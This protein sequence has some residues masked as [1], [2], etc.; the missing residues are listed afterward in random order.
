TADFER[1]VELTFR[2]SP[3]VRTVEAAEFCVAGPQVTPHVVAQQLLPAGSRRTLAAQLEPGRYRL[4]A[5]DVPGA[6][7][8]VV[9]A[10]GAAE[11]EVQAPAEGWP[12]ADEL[13]LAEASTVHLENAT[14]E[15]QLLVLERTAWS[16]QAATAAE[17]T[18]LQVFR[19][20]F[21]SEA[22]RPGEPIS[23]GSLAVVFT[24]L[25]GSTRYYREIGDAPAFGSL[26]AWSAS[27][28]GRTWSSRTQCWPIRTWPPWPGKPSRSRPSSRASRTA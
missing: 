8:V 3:G 13:A 21:A 24:D 16:D 4:R 7:P 18:A 17:V 19:D 1:S 28:R 2:P 6:L 14:A 5:L 15:E 22:L 20:L 27:R 26:L 9:S 25:K 11:A 12:A 10:D 23:V